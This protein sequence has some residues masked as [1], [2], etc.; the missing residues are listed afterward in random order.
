ML[1]QVCINQRVKDSDSG[2][3]KTSLGAGIGGSDTVGKCGEQGGEVIENKGG[4]KEFA[5]LLLVVTAV[6]ATALA[7]IF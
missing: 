4:G 3:D 1:V 5:S 6:V 7:C 2:W